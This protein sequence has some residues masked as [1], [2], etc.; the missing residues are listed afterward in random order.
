M[1]VK[2]MFAQVE[3]RANISEILELI[4]RIPRECFYIVRNERKYFR[5]WKETH[6]VTLTYAHLTK[7]H[8]VFL[9]K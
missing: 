7:L 8:G 5:G 2:T 4:F 1:F 6:V 9:P 3:R